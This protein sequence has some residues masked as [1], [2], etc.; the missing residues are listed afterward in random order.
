[1]L[2]RHWIRRITMIILTWREEVNC[3]PKDL[4]NCQ[5]LSRCMQIRSKES[6][7]V[8][9]SWDDDKESNNQSPNGVRNHK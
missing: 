2:F 3:Q 8:A 6:A 7:A 5:F 9:F 4:K 1:M